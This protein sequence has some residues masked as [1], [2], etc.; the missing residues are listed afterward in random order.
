MHWRP[1]LPLCFLPLYFY[2]Y[3]PLF[4]CLFSLKVFLLLQSLVPTSGSPVILSRLFQTEFGCAVVAA[5]G[6]EKA[7]KKVSNQLLKYGNAW[8]IYM[9]SVQITMQ[10]ALGPLKRALTYH[11]PALF[12]LSAAVI[13]PWSERVSQLLLT[14]EMRKVVLIL[15]CWSAWGTW[16]PWNYITNHLCTYVLLSGEKVHSFLHIFQAVIPNI[17]SRSQIFW[18]S[19]YLEIAFSRQNDSG[20]DSILNDL[21]PTLF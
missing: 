9:L 5:K 6:R 4:F 7:E 19:G 1:L 20:I 12:S 3:D 15:C 11:F 21:F 16:I 8:V 18:F 2:G 17:L 14:C 13:V 10:P